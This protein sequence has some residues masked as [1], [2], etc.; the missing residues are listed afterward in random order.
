MRQLFVLCQSRMKKQP[1]NLGHHSL[2]TWEW[3][4]YFKLLWIVGRACMQTLISINIFGS[5]VAFATHWCL[6]NLAVRCHLDRQWH[7][8]E[9]YLQ[10]LEFPRTKKMSYSLVYGL[11][12]WGYFLS[13]GSLLSDDFTLCQVDIH[14]CPVQSPHPQLHRAEVLTLAT[15]DPCPP[16]PRCSNLSVSSIWTIQSWL[17]PSPQNLVLFPTLVKGCHL[18]GYKSAHP[19]STPASVYFLPT[20]LVATTS[21]RA[22]NLL[23]SSATKPPRGGH[24]H[25]RRT[26]KGEWVLRTS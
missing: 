26:G 3:L 14:P 11:I 12:L 24:S 6:M 17:S 5:E 1:H 18:A 9:K 8:S 13:W 21:H 10:L 19:S 2:V 22:H 25:C 4:H 16:V 7:S 20:R 23:P 15:S